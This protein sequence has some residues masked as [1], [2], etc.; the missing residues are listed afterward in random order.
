MAY[1]CNLLLR[2]LPAIDRELGIEEEIIRVEP[3]DIPRP[4]HS[5]PYTGV[6]HP[7]PREVY[8]PAPAPGPPQIQA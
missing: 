6:V 7:T 1:T 4:D 5:Q 8:R 2:T 3:G